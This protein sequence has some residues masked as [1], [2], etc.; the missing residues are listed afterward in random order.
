MVVLSLTLERQL[1]NT[2]LQTDRKRKHS[3][4]QHDWLKI[5]SFIGLSRVCLNRRAKI[6]NLVEVIGIKN[7]F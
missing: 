5:L 7:E 4:E 2:E 3:H 1:L 6:E